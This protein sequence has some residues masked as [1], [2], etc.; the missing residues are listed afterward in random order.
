[1]RNLKI[2]AQSAKKQ[3]QIPQIIL[4]KS[5]SIIVLG[6]RIYTTKRRGRCAVEQPKVGPQGE[7][8][9]FLLGEL[10]SSERSERV[11]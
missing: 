2:P 1:M 11:K 3:R 10:Y 8:S 9:G 6:N 7:M 5:P 4:A